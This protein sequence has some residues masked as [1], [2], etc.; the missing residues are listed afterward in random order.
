MKD[1]AILANAG[2]FDVEINLADLREVAAT[3]RARCCRWSSATCCPTAA[4]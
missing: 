1:G 2:H 3:S 4:G